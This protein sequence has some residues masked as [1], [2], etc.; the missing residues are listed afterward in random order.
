MVFNMVTKVSTLAGAAA[1][2]SVAK[3]AVHVGGDKRH[4]K[5]G[6]PAGEV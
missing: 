3:A 4:D 2:I 6:Q 5:P 1:S